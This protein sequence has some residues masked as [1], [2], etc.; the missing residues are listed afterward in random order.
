MAVGPQAQYNVPELLD[1]SMDGRHRSYMSAVWG[2]DLGV[3][4]ARVPMDTMKLDPCWFP[5]FAICYFI[6]HITEI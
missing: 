5:R 3:L 4:W 1:G 2:A 6:P